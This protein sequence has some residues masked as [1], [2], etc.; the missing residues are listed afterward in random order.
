MLAVLAI[1]LLPQCGWI[2]P[3]RDVHPIKTREPVPHRCH[4]THCTIVKHKPH[5]GGGDSGP[6]VPIKP[7][8]WCVKVW[9]YKGVWYYHWRH[10]MSGVLVYVARTHVGFTTARPRCLT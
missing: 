3:C 6:R 8:Y 1:A 10:Y 5:P 4:T 9:H 2:V 7:N